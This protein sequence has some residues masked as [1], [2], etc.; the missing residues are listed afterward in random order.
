M[1]LTHEGR[2]YHAI[3]ES[4]DREMMRN[5]DDAVDAACALLEVRGV[6]LAYDDRAEE[7]VAMVV[8]F[9]EESKR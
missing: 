5:V 1:S 8:K 7:F 9:I 2:K 3:Y 6:K 4:Y